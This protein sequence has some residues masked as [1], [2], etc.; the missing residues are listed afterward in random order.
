MRNKCQYGIMFSFGKKIVN[1]YKNLIKNLMT[2]IGEDKTFENK[3]NDSDN[4]ENNVSVENKANNEENTEEG[5]E[6]QQ[7]NEID[8]LKSE[9]AELKDKFLR[10]YSEFDN[11][12]KRTNKEKVEFLKSANEELISNLLPVLD[13]FERAAR[14]LKD[15]KDSTNTN[16]E[17]INLIQHKLFKTLESK[18]LKP[19]DLAIGQEFNSELHEAI[20]QVPAPS[21]DLKG[22]IID[23]IEKGYY[24]NEKVIRFAKVIIGS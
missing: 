19:M 1:Q 11:F 24:L 4:I 2:A 20:T 23:T 22:K 10:L 16:L 9:N 17:G 6:G 7:A 8:A 14:A 5:Q 3:E 12:R 15:S 21:D 18:G 13:D